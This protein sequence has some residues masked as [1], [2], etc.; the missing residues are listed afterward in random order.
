[1]FIQ[2]IVILI[3]IYF[4]FVNAE[5]SITISFDYDM[6]YNDFYFNNIID[7]KDKH[8]YDIIKLM[9]FIYLLEFA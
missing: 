5:T 2:Y 1:M 4:I 7:S 3:I 8:K 6:N 9:I